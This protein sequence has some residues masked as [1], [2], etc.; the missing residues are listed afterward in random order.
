MVEAQG[1][2]IY[3]DEIQ[4]MIGGGRKISAQRQRSTVKGSEMKSSNFSLIDW[5]A[6]KLATQSTI[7]DGTLHLRRLCSK[8]GCDTEGKACEMSRKSIRKVQLC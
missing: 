7:A 4:G 2:R 5:S 1:V 3:F 6:R 8:R